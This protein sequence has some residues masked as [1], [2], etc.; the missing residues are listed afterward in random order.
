MKIFENYAVKNSLEVK[1]FS[2]Y[3]LEIDDL[4]DFQELHE[5]ISKKN[6]P[7]IVLGE[8]TNIV[9]PNLFNGISIKPIFNQI[10]LKDDV[11]E[12]GSSVHWHPLVNNMIDKNIHGFENLSLIPGSVGAAPIQNIGAYGQEVSNLIDEVHCYDYVNNVFIKLTNDQCNYS[13]R[14][15]LLKNTD[16][17]IYKVL[18]KTSTPNSLNLDYHSIQKYIADNKVDKDELNQKLLSNI[19]CNIRN[20]NLPDPN[21]IPNAG[22]FFKNPILKEK[23]IKTEKFSIEDLIIW[24]IDKV[25]SKV[26]AARLIDLIKDQ[27]VIDENVFIFKNH[28]LVLVTNSRASQENILDF[29]SQI[30]HIVYDTFKITLEIEPTVITN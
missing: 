16:I 23:D 29:A 3:C 14:N 27:L 26:G 7:V 12:V 15:S 4:N 8:G 30:R 5:F 24:K 19:V 2:R 9:P 25:Y 13:Y 18:F 21:I 11:V 6:L 28:S 1:S 17:V 10:D 22:S 20:Q